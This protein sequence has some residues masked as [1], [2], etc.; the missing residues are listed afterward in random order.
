MLICGDQIVM[1]LDM[2]EAIGH[3]VVDDNKESVVFASSSTL[4]QEQA[5]WE[6]LVIVAGV[7]VQ[8]VHV[9]SISVLSV[10]SVHGTL[11][12]LSHSL[13]ISDDVLEIA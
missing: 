13:G 11:V 1:V 7:Q 10:Q 2:V 12:E 8:I 6:A 5:M 3:D 9:I 4:W